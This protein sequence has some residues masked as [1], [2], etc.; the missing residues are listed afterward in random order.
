VIASAAR[1]TAAVTPRLRTIGRFL[2]LCGSACL[3]FITYPFAGEFA[4]IVSGVDTRKLAL[5]H[6][7][8]S[9]FHYGFKVVSA[10]QTHYY[11][12]NYRV[13]MSIP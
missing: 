6:L 4:G 3:A 1:Q 13:T 5:N 9:G 10:D 11:W 8:T 7:R 12:P 2:L